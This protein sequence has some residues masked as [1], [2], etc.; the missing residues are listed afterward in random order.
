MS[1]PNHDLLVIGSGPAGL[2]AALYGSRAGLKVV[3]LGGDIPG[4]QVTTHYK[5]ENFP[6]FPGG[7]T[8][9]EL[10]TR[11]L[12]QVMDETGS[13]PVYESV[14]GVDFTGPVKQVFTA[15]GSY[16]GQAVVIA[17]G[18]KARRMN[19]PG[20]SE[21][22]GRGVF[23]CATCD[24][25]LLRTMSNRRAVVV[26][27]GDTALQTSL[28]LLAHAESV[29]LITRGN[30]LRAKP[31]LMNR[32]LGDER[33]QVLTN[34]SVKA[35]FG[36]QTASGLQLENQETGVSEVFPTEAVFVGIG[37]SP[38]TEYLGGA[39]DLDEERAI[40]T[41]SSLQASL[42]GIFA[43]GDVRDTPL[44]QIVT[45]AADG[46]LAAHNAV[47]FLQNADG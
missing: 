26:G 38:V 33:I 5:V 43:A 42:P 34:R 18:A 36:T 10:M 28:A 3:I 32:I 31:A 40:V 2:T 20:E 8:G 19:I 39:L 41:D 11:W 4:G 27:G 13:M 21:F 16:R 25:P 44:R 14:T 35:V 46:A 24:A 9:A 29:T 37:Q 6:G 30:R 15:C 7:V 47:R 17:S 12:R 1:A 22:G 23:Y 45:A